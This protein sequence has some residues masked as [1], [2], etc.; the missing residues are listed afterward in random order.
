MVLSYVHYPQDTLKELYRI[1][2]PKGTLLITTLKPY[3]DLSVIYRS[4]VEHATS[5]DDI[6]EARKL[7]TSA[8]SIRSRESEG[9]FKFFS[10][11]ELVGMMS[12]VGAKNPIVSR[13]FANQAN[14][15][16]VT[17]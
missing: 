6:A 9:Q 8:G 10:E 16:I 3:A 4:F 7:L 11:A 17:K 15:I 12:A 14:I 1:L 5:S 13:S 2:A